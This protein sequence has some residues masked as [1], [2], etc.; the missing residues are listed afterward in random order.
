MSL[1][2]IVNFVIFGSYGFPDGAPADTCVK[3]IP[4]RP[5]HKGAESQLLQNL[6]YQIRAD[7]DRYHPGQQIRGVYMFCK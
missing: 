3:K 7:T 5:H 6:P 2:F 4:N 1:L